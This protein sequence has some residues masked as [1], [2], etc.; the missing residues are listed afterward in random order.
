MSLDTFASNPWVQVLAAIGALDLLFHVVLN[1][2]RKLMATVTQQITITIAPAAPPPPPPLSIDTTQVPTSG[3]VGVAYQGEVNVEGGVPPISLSV[4]DPQD[5]PP[6][7]SMDGNGNLSGTP[8]TAGPFTFT[9]QAQD[10]AP[11]APQAQPAKS[12]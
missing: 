5:L 1:F 3:Q 12:S 10:S 6:G 7:I 8:T 2:W 11:S 9:V 4:T